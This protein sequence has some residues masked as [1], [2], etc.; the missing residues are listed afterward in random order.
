MYVVSPHLSLLYFKLGCFI[1]RDLQ[2]NF[3]LKLTIKPTKL[4]QFS[5]ACKNWGKKMT[6]WGVKLKLAIQCL[7]MEGV[8]GQQMP[9]TSHNF[10]GFFFSQLLKTITN[11]F[12]E[13]NCSQIEQIKQIAMDYLCSRNNRSNGVR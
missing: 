12:E 7:Q 3:T 8:I 13:Q 1:I 6:I 9:T 5:H 4:Q 2:H 10:N 11:N